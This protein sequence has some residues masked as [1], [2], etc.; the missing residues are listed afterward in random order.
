MLRNLVVGKRFA[1]QV[2]MPWSKKGVHLLPQIRTQTLDGSLR[3]MFT[4]WSPAMVSANDTR[5]PILAVS[6]PKHGGSRTW[7]QGQRHDAAAA[8]RNKA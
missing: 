2:Q 7:I 8:D 4:P 6:D 3:T 1:K 5:V